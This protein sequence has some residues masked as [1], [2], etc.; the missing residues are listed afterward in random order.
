MD[1]WEKFNET[2]LPQKEDFYSHLDIEDITHVDYADAK[3]IC[4][5]FE[6]ENI[7]E[8]YDLHV[9][10]GILLLAEVFGKFRNM[11]IKIYEL[12]P[13]KFF[14]DP[15]LPRQAA[16]KKT[17]V[18]LNFYLYRCVINRRKMYKRSNI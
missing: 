11:C 14:S 9:Q 15:G 4:K 1:N 3:R 13:A 7:G 16:L 18:K 6:I 10:S 8:F 2:L 5:Y 17:K 12:D